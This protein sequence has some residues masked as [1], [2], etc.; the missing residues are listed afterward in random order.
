M[1]WDIRLPKVRAEGHHL[2]STDEETKV[3]GYGSGAWRVLGGTKAGP[4]L[5]DS[6]ATCAH[7]SHRRG[8]TPERRRRVQRQNPQT[9]RR[10]SEW[11]SGRKTSIFL[12]SPPGK[13]GALAAETVHSGR[14]S[15]SC[16]AP[17]PTWSRPPRTTCGE[18]GE[19]ACLHFM[20]F[21]VLV[22]PF[23]APHPWVTTS[24]RSSFLIGKAQ[25]STITT[26]PW[27]KGRIRDTNG[28]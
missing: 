23:H 18:V 27:T 14:I 6:K 17:S 10:D 12:P 22:P 8:G 20:D 7:S 24:P 4:G 3:A 15:C 26:I 25:M 21:R 16:H 13:K 9:L 5:C 19:W 2:V 1:C 11:S 28:S